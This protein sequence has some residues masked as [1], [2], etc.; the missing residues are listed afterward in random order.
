LALADVG[1][2]QELPVPVKARAVVEDHR[3]DVARIGVVA[4]GRTR[5]RDLLPD[6][7]RS[8][9]QPERRSVVAERISQRIG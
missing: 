5:D 8:G 3:A 7:K 2:R 4:V 1:W 6:G 9:V